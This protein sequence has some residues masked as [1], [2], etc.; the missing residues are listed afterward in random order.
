[1]F[2]KRGPFVCAVCSVCGPVVVARDIRVRDKRRARM[3]LPSPPAPGSRVQVHVQSQAVAELHD[4]L[5]P[6]RALYGL[7]RDEPPLVWVGPG[8]TGPGGFVV[9]V[10]LE[11]A[12]GAPY[13]GACRGAG[14]SPT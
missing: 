9:R 2:L 13:M 8:A 12:G 6:L 11:V 1:M 7:D 4:R 10:Q 5:T 14:K 3:F